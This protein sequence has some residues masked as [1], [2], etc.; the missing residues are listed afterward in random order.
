[1]SAEISIQEFDITPT[2]RD[3]HFKIVNDSQAAWAMR[4]LLGY[5]NK[6]EENKTIAQD[7]LSRIDAWL[8]HVNSKFDSDIAYFEAIL[9]QYARGEREGKDR[10]TIE[11]PYGKVKSRLTQPK[12]TVDEAEFLPWAKVHRPEWVQVVEKAA[13]TELKKQTQIEETVTL[14]LIAMTPDGEIVPGV[15]VESAGIN[16]SVEVD[17]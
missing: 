16:Y 14:G 1:M 2:E 9:V 12:Y 8:E 15:Q 17:K 5:Q 10:K 3:E 4:K 6:I 7:E 11:T 13:L